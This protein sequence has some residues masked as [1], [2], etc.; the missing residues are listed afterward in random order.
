LIASAAS[1]GRFGVDPFFLLS[2]Y[3][4]TELWLREQELCGKLDLRFFYLRRILRIWPLYFLGFLV[5][6]LHPLVDSQPA[7]SQSLAWPYPFTLIF[8]NE[9]TAR[10]AVGLP[11]DSAGR[12]V[13]KVIKSISMLFCCGANSFEL[14]GSD[15]MR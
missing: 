11:I 4:I 7:P 1:A 6:V 14:S 15:R 10:P 2:A 12:N 9:S 13:V 3:L 5:G 8:E